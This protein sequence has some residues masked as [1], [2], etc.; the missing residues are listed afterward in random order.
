MIVLCITVSEA[1]IS[2]HGETEKNKN[3]YYGVSGVAYAH[4]EGQ[5]NYTAETED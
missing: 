3:V 2:S 4:S 5:F 1:N